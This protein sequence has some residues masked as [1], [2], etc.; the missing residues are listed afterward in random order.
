MLWDNQDMLFEMLCFFFF[1]KRKFMANSHIN[2]EEAVKVHEDIQSKRSIGIHWATF[3]L[4]Y[5][6]NRLIFFRNLIFA[7]TIISQKKNLNLHKCFWILHKTNNIFIDIIHL[8]SALS[9]SKRRAQWTYEKQWS[10][11]TFLHHQT[12]RD[13]W[14]LTGYDVFCN[15][16]VMWY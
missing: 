4:S 5:E 15:I 11:K 12:W 16:D 7:S 13:N 9:C 1:N 3:P 14:S 8:F 6:V 10:I 2:P